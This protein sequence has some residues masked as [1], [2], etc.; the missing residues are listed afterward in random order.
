MIPTLLVFWLL[1]AS[2]LEYARGMALARAGRWVEA[3][4]AF[5]RGQREAPHDPRFPV[6]LAGVAFKRRDFDAARHHIRRALVLDPRDSYSNDFAGT[7][8]LL[9][10]NTEAALVYWNRIGKPRLERIRIEPEPR[11]DPVLVDRAFAF[12]PASTLTVEEYR[13]TRARL[14]LLDAFP[15]WTLGLEP[16]SD[17]GAFDAVLRTSG[18]RTWLSALR[19]LPFETVYPELRNPGG[20][21]VRIQSM[22]RWDQQKRRAWIAVSGPFVRRPAWHYRL[23]FDGRNENWLIPGYDRFN[24]KRT[25]AAGEIESVP[26]S[27][28][29]WSA[30]A[31]VVHRR[32]A[33]AAFTPGTSLEAHAG[34]TVALLRM[35]EQ[36]FSIESGGEARLGRFFSRGLYSRTQGSLAARWFP[37][38]RDDDYET[39]ARFRAGAATG[40]LPFD[41]LF[42]LGLERDNDLW[43]RAHIGTSSGRKGSAPIGPRFALSNWDFEKIVRQGGLYSVRIGPFFDTGRTWGSPGTRFGYTGWMFDTGVQAELRLPGLA[44]IVFTWGKDLRTGR[45][46]WYANLR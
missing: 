9:D 45:N 5:E 7:L 46:A 19:G 1:G 38:A 22:L 11:L 4:A 24:L 34:T 14:E 18:T 28:L 13:L 37:R 33:N 20:H 44:R 2:D 12:A 42:Q 17:A 27:R 15:V 39:S 10:G 25:E 21:A 40:P 3:E 36:R 26:V 6:E 8:A 29:K 31:G 35:P 16:R 41:E 32:F 30:G 43:L 23:F